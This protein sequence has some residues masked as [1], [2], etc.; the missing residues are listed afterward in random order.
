M[1]NFRR[2]LRHL[3]LAGALASLAPLSFADAEYAEAWGP[4]IGTTAPLLAATDQNGKDQTLETLKGTN[5]ILLV[6]NRSVDW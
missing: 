3:L 6:F 2:Q 5:G 4:D 1:R